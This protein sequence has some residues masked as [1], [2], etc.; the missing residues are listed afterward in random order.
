MTDWLDSGGWPRPAARTQ[1]GRMSDKTL[2]II[3]TLALSMF[4]VLVGFTFGGG[5]G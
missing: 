1:G 3:Y 2:F 4:S 5:W